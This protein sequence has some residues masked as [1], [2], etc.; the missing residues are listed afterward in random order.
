MPSTAEMPDAEAT[1]FSLASRVQKSAPKAAAPCEMLFIAAMGKMKVPPVLAMSA[2][3]WVSTGIKL[4][5]MPVMT[6]G[7]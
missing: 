7:A 4:L 3:S 5:C 1:P 2:M 6:T